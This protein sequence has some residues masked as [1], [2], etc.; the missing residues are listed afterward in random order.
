MIDIHFKYSFNLF[1]GAPKKSVEKIKE[2]K[3]AFYG[4]TNDK[5]DLVVTCIDKDIRDK[6]CHFMAIAYELFPEKK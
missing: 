1:G 5:V 4:V 3:I 6:L 2:C